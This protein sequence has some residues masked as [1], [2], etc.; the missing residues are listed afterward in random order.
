MGW[1]GILLIVLLST[2]VIAFAAAKLLQIRNQ[3]I[4]QSH[5]EE[6]K[7][8]DKAAGPALSDE[9]GSDVAVSSGK[10]VYDDKYGVT[11]QNIISE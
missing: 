7:D 10:D 3:R 11:S 8:S 1:I 5:Q 6:D 4:G 2:T 9:A